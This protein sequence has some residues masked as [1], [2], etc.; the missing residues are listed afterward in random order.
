MFKFPG[1]LQNDRFTWCS[2]LIVPSAHYADIFHYRAET[3]DGQKVFLGGGSFG[4]VYEMIEVTT[5]QRVAMKII[6]GKIE[7]LNPALAE[8][9]ILASMNH[10]HIIQLLFDPFLLDS[11]MRMCCIPLEL[12]PHGNLGA[13]LSELQTHSIPWNQNVRSASEF[14]LFLSCALPLVVVHP[15]HSVQ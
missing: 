1:G 7:Q 10:P 9:R 4:E 2:P 15:R 13:Y 3:D 11:P 8:A 5:K 6:M 14:R 12:A